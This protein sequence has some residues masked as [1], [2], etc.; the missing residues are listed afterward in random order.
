VLADGEQPTDF[1]DIK[2]PVDVP[3]ER[4][5][6]SRWPL[7]AAI[8]LVV[9]AA[10]VVAFVLSRHRKRRHA[11]ERIVPPHEW[12]LAALESLAARKLIEQSMFHE[13]YFQLTDIVR[14]YIERRF[15]IMAPERTTDEFLRETR[16]DPTLRDD[17]KDLLGRF[18]RAADMVKFARHEP[19]AEE[20][21]LAFTAARGFVDETAPGDR[22]ADETVEAAA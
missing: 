10:V 3:V 22:T 20:A 14:Q 5:L 1:R 6:A 11:V 16:R 4:P 18:L 7:G 17:H 21:G 12:A 15:S 8:L 19:T 13:F 2:S 9:A